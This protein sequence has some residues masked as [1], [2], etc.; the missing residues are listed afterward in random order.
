MPNQ[1][2]EHCLQQKL[3]NI[4]TLSNQVAQE[5]NKLWINERTMRDQIHNAF[6]CQKS[7]LK[8]REEQLLAELNAKLKEEGEKIHQKQMEL[9]DATGLFIEVYLMLG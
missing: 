4:H 1:I 7:E 5:L 8:T 2:V 6:A 9:F 3:T